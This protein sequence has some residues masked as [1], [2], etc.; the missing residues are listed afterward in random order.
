MDVVAC[1]LIVSGGE[2]TEKSD[3]FD[4]EDD[5]EEEQDKDPDLKIFKDRQ[6]KSFEQVREENRRVQEENRDQGYEETESRR[7]F[8]VCC[9]CEDVFEA[10][11]YMMIRRSVRATFVRLVEF[12]VFE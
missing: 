12:R 8:Y 2:P 6:R 5:D 11:S 7:R 4:K 3:E 9:M 1:Y 10:T